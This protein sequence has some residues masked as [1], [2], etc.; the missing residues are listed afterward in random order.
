MTL[1][2]VAHI[3]LWRSEM[4][5]GLKLAFTVL[6]AIGW[7]IVLAPILLIDRWLEA[8]KKRNEDT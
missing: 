3:F 1:I 2:V 7:T 4:E 6:N 8:I 5:T